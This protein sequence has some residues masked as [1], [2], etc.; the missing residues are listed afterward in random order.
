MAVK[1]YKKAD[2][3][4]LSEYFSV[5][6]FRCGLGSPCS[7]PTTLIDDQLVVYLTKIREH[8]GAPVTIT[9]GYRCPSYNSRPSV[10]GATGSRHTKGQACDIVVRGVAPR[11]VAA[12][13]ESI[14]VLGI[15]LY[16]TGGDGYFVHIDTRTTKSFW[17]GQAQEWRSTFGGAAA[18]GSAAKPSTSAD[19]DDSSTY[20]LEQFIRNVQEA[21]GAAV[22]GVAGPETLDKTVTLSMK[23]NI[24][25]AAV[26]AVQRRL[27]ALGYSEAGS[28]DGVAGQKFDQAVKRFQR[29]H[30]CEEDGEVTAKNKTWR[31]LLGMN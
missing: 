13:A 8:F 6:E 3:T 9:S 21:C 4:M 29:E 10:G 28:V 16:E 19:P 14:G 17:Y 11:K 5:Y 12:F 27:L 23:V 25:H 7:C 26:E 15:G 24:S 30:D 2:T 1:T 31:E 20:T 18:A 22:D